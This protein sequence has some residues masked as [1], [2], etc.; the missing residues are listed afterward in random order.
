MSGQN[1]CTF[2]GLKE[3]DIYIERAAD[4]ELLAALRRCEYAYVLASRQTGKTSLMLRM[5][6]ILRAEGVR[7]AKIDLG[8]LGSDTTPDVWYQTLAMEL[9]EG[10]GWPWRAL[11]ALRSV[12]QGLRDALYRRI[13]RN[14]YRLFGKRET[15]WLPSPEQKARIL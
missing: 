1:L 12:P 11:G 6:R 13:A 9:A 4:G 5:I 8:G 14:R 7:C 2:G 15:C 3:G 10:L